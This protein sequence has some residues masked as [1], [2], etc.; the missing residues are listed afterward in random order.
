MISL[1]E[2]VDRILQAMPVLGSERIS[3]AQ[4]AHRVIAEAVTAATDL[5]GFDNSAMDGYAVR[6][7]DVALA[8]IENP[9]TLRIVGH[10]SAGEPGN[11]EMRSGE[12]IRVFTGAP[13]PRGADAVVMQE[14]TRPSNERGASVE[15]LAAATSWENVRFQGEDVKMGDVLVDRGESVKLGALGLLA[16]AGCSEVTVTR[17]P[18]VGLLATGNELLEVGASPAP[19]KIFESNRLALAQLLEKLGAIAKV[20]PIVP[21][22]KLATEQALERALGEC[23]G[24]LTTGGVSVGDHDWVKAAFTGIGGQL[25][26]W[27]VAVRPGKPFTFGQRLGK[28]WFG[29]PGNPISAWVTA[30]L[31]MAPAIRR[32]QGA[33][34]TRWPM[35]PGILQEPVENLTSRRH[36]MRVRVDAEGRVWSAGIQASHILRP[37]AQANGLLDVPPESR[38]SAETVVRVLRWE[39]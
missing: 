9:M 17:R 13:M 3:I 18:T 19:G 38:I 16:A 1:E 12:C 32:W 8:T 4:A 6:A 14:D 35:H 36:F 26:F 37:L 24:I 11:P 34:E 10:L 33:N 22:S 25:E 2:A 28:F 23:D 21:D 30:L 39:I 31:L 20:Y 29:L 5:P 15:I 27:K 7:A